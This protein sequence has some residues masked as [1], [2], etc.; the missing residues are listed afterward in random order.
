MSISDKEKYEAF[1]LSQTEWQMALDA[2]LSDDMIGMLLQYGVSIRE[3]V[4]APWRAIGMTECQYLKR[5]RNGMSADEVRMLLFDP[6]HTFG[7]ITTGVAF[8][9]APQLVAGQRLKGSVMAGIAVVMLVSTGYASYR[10]GGLVAWAPVA[11]VADMC[12]S[13]IDIG[14]FLRNR[15]K[16]LAAE[17]PDLSGVFHY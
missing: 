11:L 13:S 7:V 12:W 4:A 2:H 1:G 9:G 6:L 16:A 8:P 10:T 14:L 17:R 5:R 3:Y 15:R